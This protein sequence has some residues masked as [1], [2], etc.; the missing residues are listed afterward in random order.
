[1]F[2]NLA[3]DCS[4]VANIDVLSVHPSADTRSGR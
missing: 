4:C 2:R 3:P 1:M